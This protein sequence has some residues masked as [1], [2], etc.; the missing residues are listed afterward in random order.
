MSVWCACGFFCCSKI[1]VGCLRED[2]DGEWGFCCIG[3]TWKIMLSC[4]RRSL[5]KRGC[6]QGRAS[7][8]VSFQSALFVCVL[9][10]ICEFGWP[11]PS[12]HPKYLTLEVSQPTVGLLQG[13]ELMTKE[14]SFC[15]EA[16]NS[17]GRPQL[18]VFL[19]FFFS[20]S[21]FL[22][23]LLQAL[24]QNCTKEII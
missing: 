3:I 7:C 6:K 1:Y 9:S 15:N 16:V 12:T 4:L 17:M 11:L 14:A 10:S 13:K 5:D 2:C 23:E 20:P 18:L 21:S 19:A 24:A 22:S 8:H